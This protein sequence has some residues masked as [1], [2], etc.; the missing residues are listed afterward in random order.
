MSQLQPLAI[1][2]PPAVDS[3]AEFRA[4]LKGIS[5]RSDTCPDLKTLKTI[6]LRY[7]SCT[8]VV[9]M[10]FVL[11]GGQS[12]VQ[13]TLEIKQ[14]TTFS[15]VKIMGL[16]TLFDKISLHSFFGAGADVV[17]QPPLD[18]DQIALQLHA[19]ARS[20]AEHVISQL[21]IER[22]REMTRST[23]NFLDTTRDGV[24]I[25]DSAGALIK[26]N[27]AAERILAL[28]PERMRESF[29]SISNSILPLL[30]T[31]R[32]QEAADGT[33]G[34]L[35]SSARVLLKRSDGRNTTILFRVMSLPGGG[36][37]QVGFAFGVID[38]SIAQQ[39][40]ARLSNQER[41]RTLTLS[42]SCAALELLNSKTLGV[43][44][45]P[46]ATIERLLERSPAPAILSDVIAPL[47]EL[48]DQALPA[49]TAIRV[50]LRDDA[51]ILGTRADLYQLL[52]SLLWYAVERAGQG[53]ETMIESERI[54]SESLSVVFSYTAH[55]LV[56]PIS[57]DYFLRLAEGEHTHILNPEAPAIH[58]LAFA[59]TFAERLGVSIEAK[60]S[61][62]W[63]GKIRVLLP[64]A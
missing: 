1:I 47:I 25:V 11:E 4:L 31:H 30:G 53:G 39:I 36:G 21:E 63:I 15:H 33:I 59:Q 17:L 35:V 43:P 2:F 44:G 37:E 20:S 42:L 22:S 62:R 57:G 24:L 10:P 28:D 54:D 7:P 32:A 9:L 38:L 50:S 64:C 12:G 5:I 56:E 8:P 14:H 19:L 3:P 58:T 60:S 55:E 26:A 52:G 6:L 61:N 45:R 41:M 51:S 13:R 34:S 23:M 48:A 27:R 40:A 46:L 29:N 49:A 18:C 16:L